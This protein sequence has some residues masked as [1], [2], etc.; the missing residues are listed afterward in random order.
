[1]ISLAVSKNRIAE[2]L[3]KNLAIAMVVYY[4]AFGAIS[5]ICEVTIYYILVTAIDNL[6]KM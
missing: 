6:W 3:V 5:V 1:M 2:H 4:E